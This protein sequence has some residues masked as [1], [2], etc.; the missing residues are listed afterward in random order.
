V[1]YAFPVPPD[2][3][4]SAIDHQPSAL[5]PEPS[6]L[7]REPPKPLERAVALL[8]VLV[9]SDFP[10]QFALVAT[11]AAFG[12]R[13]DAAGRLSL[14]YVA[15]LS[16]TDTAFLLALIV[17]FL[18]AHG[19]RPRDVFIGR[20]PIGG[21]A[22]LGVPL[23]IVT[24][25]IAIA[26]LTAL[27]WLAPW[28]HTVAHNPLQDLIASPRQAAGFGVVVVVAGG[29]REEMQRAFLLHRFEASLGGATF[30]LAVT[31][32]A[33]GAGHFDLQGADAAIT[34]ALLGASWGIVYLR[35]RSAVAPIV[36]HA[37]FDVL[38]IL[39]VHFFAIRR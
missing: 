25:G 20:R 28:L 39:V 7:R 32:L 38:Q 19:E 5:R 33:F 4:P 31:S 8:E 10:T 13:P 6:A 37:G 26:V 36:S 23:T 35:R 2:T 21:E 15:A 17:F 34:T 9:C 27:Q 14:G 22:L 11:F 1:L 30:G 16:L 3:D 29:V 12:F 24:L 18:R